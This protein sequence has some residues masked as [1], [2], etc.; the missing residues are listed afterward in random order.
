VHLHALPIDD[1]PLRE[2]TVPIHD[3]QIAIN[4]DYSVTRVVQEPEG[5]EL[6]VTKTADGVHV[7]V[8]QLDIHTMVVLELAAQR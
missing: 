8:P 5:L 6:R 3:I 1:V 2:E 7:T 4:A